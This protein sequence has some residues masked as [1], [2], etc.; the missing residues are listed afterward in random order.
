MS[1]LS[2]LGEKTSDAEQ[3]SGASAK[4]L[5]VAHHH[6]GQERT[7]KRRCQVWW[8]E[9]FA[10]YFSSVH[11]W[12]GMA[13]WVNVFTMPFLCADSGPWR[14]MSRAW[15]AMSAITTCLVSWAVCCSFSFF[16]LFEECAWVYGKGCVNERLYYAILVR[17]L[18]TV[19]KDVQGV[20]SSIRG[21]NIRHHVSESPGVS[22]ESCWSQAGKGYCG[23]C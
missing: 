18:W 4:L 13:V 6:I 7:T 1:V 23:S 10:L 8:V 11:G 5:T 2:S 22:L 16:V 21:N 19:E 15:P 14:K 9:G 20:T 12:M 3:S 17:R